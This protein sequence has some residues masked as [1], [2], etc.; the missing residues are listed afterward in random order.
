VTEEPVRSREELV[1]ADLFSRTLQNLISLT[2]PAVERSHPS[3]AQ[4]LNATDGEGD[5]SP[6]LFRLLQ[7]VLLP[8]VLGPNTGTIL[9]LAAKRFSANLELASIQDLKAW[10]SYM[11]LGE[12]EVELDDERILVKLSEC[13]TC[14]RL[15]QVGAPLCDLE[16]GLIDGVLER[17]TGTGVV[18]KETLCWGLGDTVCQFEAYIADDGDYLYVEDGHYTEVQRRLMAGLAEQSEIALEN[19]HLVAQRHISETRDDLTG[20]FNFKHLRE[21]AHLELARARR[22]ERQVAFVMLDLDGFAAV[23]EAA[24]KDGGDVVLKEWAAELHRQVRTCDLS[25]RYGADEF[26]LVLPETAD[27]GADTALD[28]IL[29]AMKELSIVAGERTFSVTATAGVATFPDDGNLVEE[30]VAKATTTMY[31]AK[32]RGAGQVGFYSPPAGD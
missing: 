10:F 21:Y 20:L 8:E 19:L 26:L 15:P 18:T 1:L 17:I 23:N 31:V 14:H 13:L 4:V 25:C 7:L 24:G 22:Y 3:S 5:V 32:S 12:L 16:R 30:L 29:Q 27:P 11:K 9:Y 28:R 6:T 2:E